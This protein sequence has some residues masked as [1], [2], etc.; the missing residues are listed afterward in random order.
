M[1]VCPG[2]ADVCVQKIKLTTHYILPRLPT[3]FVRSL[4]DW[5]CWTHDSPLSRLEVGEEG[6]ALGGDALRLHEG[7][8]PLLELPL[9]LLELLQLLERGL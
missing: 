4:C 3:H 9:L 1:L 2:P 7:A 8:D 5:F 6:H